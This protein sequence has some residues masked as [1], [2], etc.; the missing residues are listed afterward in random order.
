[1]SECQIFN[2]LNSEE[3]QNDLK[4][5][6][7]VSYTDKYKDTNLCIKHNGFNIEINGALRPDYFPQEENIVK[8][9]DYRKY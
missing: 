1:M 3:A 9:Y 5:M 7:W 6:E 4:N 8:F 2:Y